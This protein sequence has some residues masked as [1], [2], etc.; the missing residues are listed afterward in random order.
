MWD[1]VTSD[2][3]EHLSYHSLPEWPPIQMRRECMKNVL[4]VPICSKKKQKKKRPDCSCVFSA[5]AG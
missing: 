5:Q 2:N 1:K 3:K 4:L